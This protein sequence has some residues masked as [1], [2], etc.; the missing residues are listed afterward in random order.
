MSEFARYQTIWSA[1]SEWVEPAV[2][3]VEVVWVEPAVRVVEVVWVEPVVRGV[4]VVRVVEVQNL[5][6]SLQ[7]IQN[8]QTNSKN[9]VQETPMFHEMDRLPYPRDD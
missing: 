4:G 1:P 5:S 7:M 9:L 6:S 8:F 2:R 3:V